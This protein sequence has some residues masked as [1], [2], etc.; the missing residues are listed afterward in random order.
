MKCID[1]D[2]KCSSWVYVLE[3]MRM[4]QTVSVMIEDGFSIV[5]TEQTRAE[6]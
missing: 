2:L 5:S 1:K 4:K 3:F 6:K